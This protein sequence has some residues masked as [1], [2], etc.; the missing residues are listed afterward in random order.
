[1]RLPSGVIGEAG[2]RLCCQPG[3]QDGRQCARAHVGE[4]GVVQHEVAVAGPQEIK[5]VQPALRRACAEPGEVVIAD[6]RAEAVGRLVPRAG[7]VDRNPG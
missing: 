3:D 5:E 7:V 2:F 4:R 6:L 1:M